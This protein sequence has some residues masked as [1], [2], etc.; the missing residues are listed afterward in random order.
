MKTKLTVI[1]LAAILVTACTTGTR[2]TKTYDDDIYF[3]PADAPPVTVVDNADQGQRKSAKMSNNDTK[4]NKIVMSQI[5][6]NA[7]GSS[8]VNNYIYQQD[9]NKTNQDYQSYQMTDQELVESDTTVYTNDDDVKYVINNYYD[10]DD[11]DI[12]FAYRI[13]RFH[14]PYFSP[15]FYND[16]YYYDGFYSPWYSGYYGWGLYDSWYYGGYGYGYPYYYGYY[17]PFAFGFGGYWG[18]GGYYNCYWNGY[19][20]GYYGSGGGFYY[21]HQI[22]RR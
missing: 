20:N 7:D 17:S 5:D 2:L 21:S 15:Y 9:K 13:N 3:S 14:R 8:T 12:D 18:Y 22:A 19:Y 10:E 4:D 11:S 16:W 1:S 6:R